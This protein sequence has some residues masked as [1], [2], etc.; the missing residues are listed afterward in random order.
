LIFVAFSCGV[1]V[2]VW[3]SGVVSMRLLGKPSAC[4]RSATH[5]QLH[6]VAITR[7]GFLDCSGDL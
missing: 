2:L 5:G 3:V 6:R 4:Q 7:R 1:I